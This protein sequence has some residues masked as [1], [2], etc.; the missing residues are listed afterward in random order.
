ML[1]DNYWGTEI[2]QAVISPGSSHSLTWWFAEAK[3]QNPDLGCLEPSQETQKGENAL[4]T[5]IFSENFGEAEDC[6]AKSGV[7][8]SNTV[9]RT[10]LQSSDEGDSS[11]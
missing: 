2:I 1:W 5:Q 6:V 10:I 8:W 11:K 3:R 4:K 7:H 9:Q